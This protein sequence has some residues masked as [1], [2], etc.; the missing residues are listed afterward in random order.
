MANRTTIVGHNTW[1]ITHM[2][3][4]GEAMASTKEDAIPILRALGVDYIMVVFGGMA[5]HSGDDNNKLLWM[6]RIAQREFPEAMDEEAYLNQGEYREDK[7]DRVA[8]LLSLLYKMCSYR[9]GG[10]MT[11]YG[12]PT[13]FDRVRRMEIGAK[14]FELDVV[15][16]AYTTTNWIV[17]IYKVKDLDNRW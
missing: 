17:R 1:N 7:A 14:D 6:V 5:G 9:F 2:A 3:T 8:M 15:Q 12:K 10:A 11:E 13:K 16:E 4:V